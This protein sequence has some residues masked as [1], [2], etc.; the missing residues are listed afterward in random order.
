MRCR[1][2][3][4]PPPPQ[5]YWAHTISNIQ[6]QVSYHYALNM[7]VCTCYVTEGFITYVG[8]EGRQTKKVRDGYLSSYLYAIDLG[9]RHQCIR[10]KWVGC[11]WHRTGSRRGED[12][13]TGP[14]Q[15]QGRA[16]VDS[17]Q[18]RGG[19]EDARAPRQF[20]QTGVHCWV[21]S[22]TL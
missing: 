12:E 5:D 13:Y 22:G 8:V 10:N 17:L 3:L 21:H 11:G 1:P 7:H 6:A 15:L 18:T 4:L 19:G 2:G 9:A 20:Y 14:S 16:G